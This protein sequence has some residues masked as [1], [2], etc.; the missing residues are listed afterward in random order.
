VC[1]HPIVAPVDL[2]ATASVMQ[3]RV[4]ASSEPRERALLRPR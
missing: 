3:S 2:S 4:A 1:S